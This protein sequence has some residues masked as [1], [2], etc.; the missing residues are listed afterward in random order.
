M[1]TNGANASPTGI[2][3]TAKPTTIILSILLLAMCVV[4]A[5]FW[6]DM[7]SLNEAYA[8]MNN[9]EYI[10]SST[11]R[12]VSTVQSNQYTQKEIFFLSDATQKALQLGQETTLS[13]LKDPS[14]V[15][16]AND[17]LE[18][19]S[20]IETLLEVRLDEE[21]KVI[22]VDLID[23]ALARDNHF[24]SMTDLSSAISGYASD[25][26][27]EIIRYQVF[28]LVLLFLMVMIALYNF[29][30]THSELKLSRELAEAA[31]IDLATGLYNRS[32]C[33][34]LFKNN[35]PSSS[36][37][38]PAIL[39]LDLNDLKK[40]NDSLGHRVGDELIQSF[41]NVLKNASSVHVVPPFI[42]RYGGDEFIVYYEDVGGEEEVTVYLKELDFCTREFNERETRFQISYAVGYSYVTADSDEK[43]TT[44]Q[45][46]DKA[47]AAM[48]ENK[49]AGKKEKN[50]D[51]DPDLARGE[52]R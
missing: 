20:Q 40:T 23:L 8:D 44:R 22:P 34:E 46:F 17:V 13:V 28:F 16:L 47:D 27:D 5:L 26:S 33:Q 39:V 29:L 30:K 11:Q 1:N 45:L 19:W 2:S 49:I 31:Q 48:Y 41:A 50:P 38:N 36:R 51:Y 18:S 15:V 32:R 25:L 4:A 37:K 12:L 14:M 3:S 10:S 42:G 21:E 24:R 52:V 9:I 43:L 6:M 35:N 7:R